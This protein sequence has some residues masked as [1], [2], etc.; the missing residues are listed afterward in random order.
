MLYNLWYCR[1]PDSQTTS[2]SS[3]PKQTKTTD[4]DGFLVPDTESPRRTRLTKRAL[5][6][7]DF[8]TPANPGP[9]KTSTPEERNTGSPAK[10]RKNINREDRHR[11]VETTTRE[12][13]SDIDDNISI[14]KYLSM[15]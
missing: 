10:Y 4:D 6:D 9:S 7:N 13:M 12:D 1:S 3:K 15:S 8:K 14:C 5:P 11:P 2:R